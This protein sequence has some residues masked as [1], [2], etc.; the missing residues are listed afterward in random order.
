ML[1][2]GKQLVA[3]RATLE[4]DVLEAEAAV[5]S[6][7]DSSWSPRDTAY[8]HLLTSGVGTQVRALGDVAAWGRRKGRSVLRRGRPRDVDEVGTLQVDEDEDDTIT[9]NMDANQAAGPA[10]GAPVGGSGQG[11]GG[12]GGVEFG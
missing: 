12:R 1:G 7:R 8:L 9:K 6:V 11:Q 3:L 10:P 5:P 4:R 2:S